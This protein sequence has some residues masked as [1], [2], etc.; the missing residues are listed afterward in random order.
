M[1]RNNRYKDWNNA[2]SLLKRRSRCRP[3]FDLLKVPNTSGAHLFGNWNSW[4]LRTV[5]SR[6]FSKQKNAALLFVMS[7]SFG[8]CRYNNH[9]KAQEFF[10][11]SFY[12]SSKSYVAKLSLRCS[13][14]QCRNPVKTSNKTLAWES[15]LQPHPLPPP[16]YACRCVFAFVEILKLDFCEKPK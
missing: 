6:P 12:E 1:G 13:S 5:L 14:S 4:D 10:G 8:H 15:T 7:V 9:S 11:C 3:S 2:N 16:L